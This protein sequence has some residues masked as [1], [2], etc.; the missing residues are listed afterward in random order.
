MSGRSSIWLHLLVHVH[1][2][3]L[4]EKRAQECGDEI[5]GVENGVENWFPAVHSKV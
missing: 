4:D 1:K 5:F 2:I 3:G